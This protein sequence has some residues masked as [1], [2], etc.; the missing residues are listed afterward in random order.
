[1]KIIK[2]VF[3][4]FFSFSQQAWAVNVGHELWPKWNTIVIWVI[5]YAC[6]K[7]AQLIRPAQHHQVP[8]HQHVSCTEFMKKLR[9]CKKPYRSLESK[10]KT[11]KRLVDPFQTRQWL[12]WALRC[13]MPYRI[14]SRTIHPWYAMEE[15]GQCVLIKCLTFNFMNFAYP[16]LCWIATETIISSNLIRLQRVPVAVYLLI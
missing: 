15:L 5:Q 16:A 13:K 2:S 1:M 11:M 4:T 9:E 7:I 10:R 6:K 3:R 14:Q 8:V 12:I